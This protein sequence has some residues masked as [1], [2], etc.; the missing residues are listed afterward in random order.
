MTIHRKYHHHFFSALFFFS[1]YFFCSLTGYSQQNKP[2]IKVVTD[3]ITVQ[4]IIYDTVVVYDTVIVFDTIQVISQEQDSGV[5]IKP[6]GIYPGTQT[7]KKNKTFLFSDLAW[8]A[9]LY[10]V[11]GPTEHVLTTQQQSS[12]DLLNFKDKYEK[13]EPGFILGMNIS[14][15]RRN[16]LLQAGC[17]YWQN[18]QKVDYRFAD[19]I[20]DTTWVL[21]SA[22]HKLNPRLDT[23]Y[24]KW[25][26]SGKN[27]YVYLEFPFSIGYKVFNDKK[28]FI[29]LKG[30]AVL[31]M[32]MNARGKLLSFNDPRKFVN[33]ADLPFLKYNIS[34]KVGFDMVFGIT[35]NISVIADAFLM[36]SIISNFRIYPITLRYRTFG[37]SAG[38]RFKL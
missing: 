14:C 21:D 10:S 30:G 3:T 2:G 7:K 33:L 11:F 27:Q 25:S 31:D 23:T 4:K 9:D 24:N 19:P 12:L 8:A 20:V 16:L 13:P 37:G 1:L 32:F 36:E 18:R 6:D 22:G 38:I 28:F 17:I 26:Y 35:K 34:V 29:Y 5:I 15:F